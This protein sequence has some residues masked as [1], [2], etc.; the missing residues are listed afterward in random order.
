M[1]R[2]KIWTL[3]VV[4]LL[5]GFAAGCATAQDN[6]NSN[7]PAEANAE[8]VTANST[9]DVAADSTD[10]DID[11][12]IALIQQYYAYYGEGDL[13]GIRS[14]MAPDVTWTLPGRHPLSRTFTGVDAVIGFFELLQQTSCQAELLFLEANETYVIDYHRG[15]CQAG[16]AVLDQNFFLVFEIQGGLIQNVTNTPTDQHAADEWYTLAYGDG[17]ETSSGDLQELRDRQAIIDTINAVGIYA[18]FGEWD[19]V[20]NQF[21]DEVILDYNSYDQAAVGTEAGD[22]DTLTPAEVVAAWQTVLPGYDY[23][24]HIIGNHQVEFTGDDTAS[25]T[26]SVY[27]SHFLDNNDGENYWVFIGNYEHELVRTADGWKISLMRANLRAELGN[28]NLPA[29]ATERVSQSQ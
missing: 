8:D 21:A 24:Q 18:D 17:T 13:E 16:D 4:S 29:L 7:G 22:P 9:E 20:Q 27:A 26:S 2:H 25:A 15:I 28:S 5:A 1:M 10:A 14:V 11:P 19:Q 12:N 6:D 23:T 3:I